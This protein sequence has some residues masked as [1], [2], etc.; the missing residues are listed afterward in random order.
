MIGAVVGG[1]ISGD[2]YAKWEHTAER[3]YDMAGAEKGQNLIEILGLYGITTNSPIGGPSIGPGN[4]YVAD[5]T[6]YLIPEVGWQY[7]PPDNIVEIVNSIPWFHLYSAQRV[8][9][10]VWAT[11]YFSKGKVQPEYFVSEQMQ[12]MWGANLMTL[13][14]YNQAF[15]NLNEQVYFYQ[16]AIQNP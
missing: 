10:L 14:E 13:D 4:Y 7:A 2:Q 11:Y 8:K 3:V 5:G 9:D 1:L 6:K 15:A 16:L 12:G